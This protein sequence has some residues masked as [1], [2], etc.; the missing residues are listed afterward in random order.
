ME[1]GGQLPQEPP[2]PSGPHALPTQSGTQMHGASSP[3]SHQLFGPKA[4]QMQMVS[5]VQNT[6]APTKPRQP[7]SSMAQ[8]LYL[9][10]VVQRI[11]PNSHLFWHGEMRSSAASP[12]EYTSGSMTSAPETTS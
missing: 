5:G 3:G 11:W 6:V 9:V 12:Y 4:E 1:P 10:S 7:S 2:Q 8:L